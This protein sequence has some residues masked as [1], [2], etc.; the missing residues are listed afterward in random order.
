V[1][2]YLMGDLDTGST[3]AIGKARSCENLLSPDKQAPSTR[4][5]ASAMTLTGPEADAKLMRI[6]DGVEFALRRA[7]VWSKYAKDVISY[8][9]KRANLEA[10]HAR[11]LLKL[12]QTMRPVLKEESFLPFQSIYCTAIDQDLD[13]ANNCLSNCTLL[14]DHKF[15]EPL[16]ARRNEHEKA[17]KQLKEAWQRELKRMQ[18]L[19]A[20]V[21]K[22]RT[23]YV[24]RHQ[25]HDKAAQR[26]DGDER[27]RRVEEEALQKAR[28]AETT[29]KACVVEANE[30]IVALERTK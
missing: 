1:S 28:E 2:E 10:E 12:A 5:Y 14:H 29:Y 13:N 11:N 16:T 20:N 23:L 9:E 24:Q 6:D 18:E 22:A 27:R 15:V 21:R 4:S 7:K 17:R 30:R 26:A 3:S 19:E 8:V 25:E